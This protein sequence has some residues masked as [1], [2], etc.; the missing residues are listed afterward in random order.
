LLYFLIFIASSLV[1]CSVFA[2]DNSTL[3]LYYSMSGKTRIVASELKALMPSAD[4]I[5]IK[6]DVGIPT[7][8]FWHLL[9][10]Q[11]A[12]IQPLQ[13]DPERYSKIILCTPIWMQRISSPAKTVINTV[14]MQDKPIEVFVT[15]AGHFGEDG[16]NSVKELLSAKGIKLT[17]L[18]IIKTGDQPETGIRNQVREE[19]KNL[20]PA[21]KAQPA[22]PK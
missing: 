12:T 3:I 19:A 7:A 4:L 17:G 22:S 6:S 8:I 21:L 14:R 11:N 18:H 5:E 10:N 13:V 9:F 2:G 16:Q 20:C 15:C 1:P